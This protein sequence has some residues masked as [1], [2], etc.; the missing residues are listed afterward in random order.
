MIQ[1]RVDKIEDVC[2]NFQQTNDSLSEKKFL[3]LFTTVVRI[4]RAVSR[5]KIT[6]FQ[7]DFNLFKISS[8]FTDGLNSDTFTYAYMLNILISHVSHFHIDT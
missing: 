5:L 6:N 3:E 8:V 7:I 1:S 4:R 2:T